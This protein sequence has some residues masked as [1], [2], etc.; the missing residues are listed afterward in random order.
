[1]SFPDKLLRHVVISDADLRLES[2]GGELYV[3]T[4]QPGLLRLDFSDGKVFRQA[5]RSAGG[6]WKLRAWLPRLEQVGG[7]QLHVQVR[8][9]DKLLLEKKVGEKLRIKYGRL[10][11]P[12]LRYWM[13]K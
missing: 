13:G 8:L 5:L 6:P 11:G 3:H 1:M 10:L 12:V 2:A 9:Q 7:G 4:P